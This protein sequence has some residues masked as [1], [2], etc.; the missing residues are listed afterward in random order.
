MSSLLVVRVCIASR[1]SWIGVSTR[2]NTIIM[3]CERG[4]V[5]SQALAGL[6]QP[7]TWVLGRVHAWLIASG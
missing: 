3:N 1:A 7:L 6:K 5:S 2:K 4:R